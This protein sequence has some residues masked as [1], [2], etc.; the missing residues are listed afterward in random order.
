MLACVGHLYEREVTAKA[1]AGGD[2]WRVRQEGV[3]MKTSALV[4][5]SGRFER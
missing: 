3:N 4:G 1:A 5:R 2:V